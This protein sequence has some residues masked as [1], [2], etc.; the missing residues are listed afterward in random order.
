MSVSLC[1]SGGKY[2]DGFFIIL[3][4]REWRGDVL[5]GLVLNAVIGRDDKW[6][7]TPPRLWIGWAIPG[8]DNVFT[9]SPNLVATRSFIQPWLLII[10][11][12]SD[13]VKL[14]NLSKFGKLADWW[15]M[16]GR[17]VWNANVKYS[18][19]WSRVIPL[20]RK[21]ARITQ[22]LRLR[23][24]L[25]KTTTCLLDMRARCIWQQ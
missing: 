14:K 18:T 20:S 12:S 1:I 24:F 22:G 6:F 13:E 7:G 15:W 23:L 3:L 21:K 17:W 5:V 19:A 8:N 4:F 10:C 9:S 2:L 16:V 25:Q 11:C